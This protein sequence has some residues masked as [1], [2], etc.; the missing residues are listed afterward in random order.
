MCVWFFCFL[1]TPVFCFHWSSY[2]RIWCMNAWLWTCDTILTHSKQNN[3]LFPPLCK[4]VFSY[5]RSL[6]LFKFLD[7]FS[8][9]HLK[10]FCCNRMIQIMLSLDANRD[11][12]TKFDWHLI[13]QVNE[14]TNH[15]FKAQ[16]RNKHHKELNQKLQ[17]G[18]SH[19]IY[20]SRNLERKFFFAFKNVLMTIKSLM[21][22]YCNI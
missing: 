8:E 3:S 5:R 10:M 11:T 13:N 17:K 12:F 2:W 4:H 18:G 15:K 21:S 7:K 19:K 6:I 9:T 22:R 14:K 20:A 1:A 16:Y